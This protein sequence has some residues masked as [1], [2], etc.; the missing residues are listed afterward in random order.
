MVSDEWEESP[1]FGIYKVTWTVRVDADDKT[2]TIEK[3]VF[4][5]P[6]LVIILTIIVL[7]FIVIWIIMANRKRKERRSRLAV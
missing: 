4:L 3:V 6:P 5:V 7:T 1:N 2:E